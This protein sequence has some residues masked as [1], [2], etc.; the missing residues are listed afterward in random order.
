MLSRLVRPLAP[1]MHAALQILS[2]KVRSPSNAHERSVATYLGK[3]TV[4]DFLI[5]HDVDDSDTWMEPTTTV[6]EVIATKHLT[7]HGD[8]D[9]V[10]YLTTNTPKTTHTPPPHADLTLA[11]ADALTDDHL[12]QHLPYNLRNLKLDY[13]HALTDDAVRTVAKRSAQHLA[14][15]SVYSNQ[16][17]TSAAAVTL[18]VPST[19]R[20]ASA[21]AT[22][23]SISQPSSAASAATSAPSRDD[24]VCTDSVP[25]DD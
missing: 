3:R 8:D 6:P 20:T 21:A 2:T 7:L 4:E 22:K 10:R 13:C 25:D 1:R 18:S 14:T 12:E 5:N 23:R 17:L 11:F 19:A 9:V 24:G 16:N 15:F